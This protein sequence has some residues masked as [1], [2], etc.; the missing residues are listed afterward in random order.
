MPSFK[1]FKKWLRSL[2]RR[3]GYKNYVQGASN[4]E[5]AS[6]SQDFHGSQGSAS[7][8]NVSA[9]SEPIP[10]RMPDNLFLDNSRLP[11]AK[12]KGVQ[13]SSTAHQALQT[14]G[15]VAETSLKI[16]KEL[17]DFIPLAGQGLG[18]ALGVVSECIG[19]YHQVT[20]NKESNICSR[21][22]L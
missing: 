5:L 3:R 15:A 1:K 4:P 13:E 18:I 19:I 12:E 8:S 2:W 22:D 17:S 20:E 11:A 9:L 7:V 21:V 10:G 6:I 14:A 16:L